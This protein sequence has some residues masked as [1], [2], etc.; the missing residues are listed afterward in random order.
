MDVQ[1]MKFQVID[2]Q[3]VVLWIP[4][5]MNVVCDV[6]RPAIGN[7][8]DHLKRQSHSDRLLEAKASNDGKNHKQKGT[9]G[10]FIVR[11]MCGTYPHFRHLRVKSQLQCKHCNQAFILRAERRSLSNSLRVHIDKSEKC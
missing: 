4:C 1:D 10:A 3:L 5:N 2:K 8:R 6:K 9:D 7:V 11:Q